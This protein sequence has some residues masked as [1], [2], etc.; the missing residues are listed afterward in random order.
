VYQWWVFVH[1]VG[2]LA[3]LGA[4]GVSMVVLFRLRKERDPQKV[5]DLLTLSSSS[6][7]AFYYALG[8]L[9][10]GGIVAGFLG[11]WW[12]RAW[13]WAAIGILVLVTIAMY[14][15]ARP[16]YRRV[17][18]VARAMA[19]GSQAVTREQFDEILRGPRPITVAGIGVAG[20]LVI[21]YLMVLKPT[22]GFS[23]QEAKVS[24]PGGGPVVEVTAQNVQF[25]ASSLKAPAARSF[26]LVFHNDDPGVPHNVAIYADSSGSASLFVGK[27]FNGK[28][29]MDYQVPALPAGSYFFRC[30]VHPQMSGTLVAQGA[31]G[32]PSSSPSG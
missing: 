5:S 4:H 9:L 25:D 30:D 22:L 28:A 2:V 1:L 12:G 20:L 21:L 8:L 31:P 7:S 32:A 17:G 24:I 13:I 6:I 19:E 18:F 16:Y 14:A 26:T 29:I 23:S 3:F 15:M 11:H 10:V 27:I